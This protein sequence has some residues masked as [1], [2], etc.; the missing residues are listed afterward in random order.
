MLVLLGG[1]KTTLTTRA[2]NEIFEAT[3]TF[4]SYK[5]ICLKELPLA[6]QNG[7]RPRPSNPRPLLETY[8]SPLPQEL[9]SMKTLKVIC[10]RVNPF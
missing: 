7:G 9:N 6:H 10:M 2:E 3:S 1:Q 4:K 8:E 5:F